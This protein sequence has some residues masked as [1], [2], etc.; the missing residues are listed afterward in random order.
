MVMMVGASILALGVVLFLLLPILRGESASLERFAGELTDA[1]ARKRAALRALRDVDYD[2]HTGKLDDSDYHEL[3]TALSHDALIAMGK[4]AAESGRGGSTVVAP[5]TDEQLEAE[6]ARVRMGLS[7][8]WVCGSCE[9]VNVEESRFCAMCGG[10]LAAARD[11]GVTGVAEEAEDSES[12]VA[13]D[14][15]DE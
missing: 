10:P 8:G 5:P 14:P 9:H 7:A 13:P 4:V 1:E 12:A 3:K 15:D 2:Y 11:D 6:I